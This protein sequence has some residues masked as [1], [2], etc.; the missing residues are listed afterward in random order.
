MTISIP[1]VVIVGVVGLLGVGLYALLTVRNLIKVIVGLQIMVKGT[2]IAFV[3]A[4]RLHGQ[5]NLG[6]SLALTVIVADTIVAV[7]GLALAVQVRRA[8]GTMNLKD[9][10]TLRR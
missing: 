10:T 5:E 7:I 9:L 6:Q 3:L 1:S 2:M 8:F 4:G